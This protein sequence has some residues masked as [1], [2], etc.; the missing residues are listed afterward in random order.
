MAQI[1]DGRAV[2]AALKAELRAAVAALPS[3]PQLAIVEVGAD[4]AAAWYI[5]AI[6]KAAAGVG[7]AVIH[8]G[9]PGDSPEAVVVAA[10]AALSADPTVSGIIIQMPLPKPLDPQ[11]VIAALDPRK[12]V[13]GLHP[14]NAGRLAQGLPALLPNTPAGGLELLRFYNL[15]VAG[16]RA[17]VV[18]RSNVVGKPLALLLLQA[19]ATVTIC[20]SRT[21]DLAAVVR[22]ADLVAVAVGQ[23]GLVTGAMLSLAR[24]CWTLASTTR[25]ARWSAMSTGLAPS[26]SPARSRRCRAGLAPS[27][28]CCC[29]ATPSRPTATCRAG[30]ERPMVAPR[31]GLARRGA[32]PA[33]GTA[34]A[35]TAGSP[36][37]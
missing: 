30:R 26:R 12:D 23:P 32:G 20:H 13:D 31:R 9:L 2:A 8:H 22:E 6:N 36:A 28:T 19:H 1:L 16:Q 5:R 17:V 10:V 18:G 37:E 33:A 24:L 34:G 3:A 11:V 25:P 7:I 21:P 14:V 35:I 29:C 15:P 4:P 27:P